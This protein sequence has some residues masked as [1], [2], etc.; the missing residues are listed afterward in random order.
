[1]ELPFLA[2]AQMPI[3]CGLKE[4]E[5]EKMRCGEWL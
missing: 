2:Q 3:T 5:R 4:R 1:M